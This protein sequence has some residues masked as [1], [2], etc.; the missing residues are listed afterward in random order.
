MIRLLLAALLLLAGCSAKAEPKPLL[1]VSVKANKQTVEAFEPVKITTAVTLNDEQIDDKL[2][3]SYEV[4]NPS[5]ISVGSVTP[6]KQADGRYMIETS[7]DETGT[8]QIVSHVSYASL[9]EMP[10]VEVEVR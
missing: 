1:D 7:F 5:S 4:I 2:D 9:H 3:I 8:Y 6:Q 10:I